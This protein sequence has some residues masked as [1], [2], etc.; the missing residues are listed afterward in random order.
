MRINYIIFVAKQ[1]KIIIMNMEKKYVSYLRCS[2]KDQLLGIES[3]RDI[4]QKYV[5]G[6]GLI[7]NE[8]VEWESG[9]KDNRIELDKAIK[10][11]KQDGSTLIIAKIDRLS[12]NVSFLFQIKDS[13]VDICVPGLPD[14]NTLMFGVLATFAQHER[15]MISERTKNALKVLKD[16]GIKLGN[17]DNLMNNMDKAQKEAKR[18][19][20]EKRLNNQNNRLS[21]TYAKL[22][23]SQGVKFADIVDKMNEYGCLSSNGLPFKYVSQ[24]QRLLK[25]EE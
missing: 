25:D 24:I 22:L 9:K 10:Q 14:L 6:K 4:V 12:R 7:I 8:Y 19:Q 13:G 21:T 23:R 16:K 15:E 2:T 11:C 17:P 1:I 18:V 20:K 3:Q 5:D